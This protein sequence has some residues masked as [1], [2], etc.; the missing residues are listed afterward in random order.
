[1]NV[2]E[3]DIKK[4]ERYKQNRK[5][6]KQLWLELNP[7]ICTLEKK[8]TIRSKLY[9]QEYYKKNKERLAKY[10]KDWK[11][12][13]KD[14]VTITDCIY[15]N[16]HL[17]RYREYNKRY[18]ENN[19]VKI[20]L[21]HSLIRDKS[22]KKY[23]KKQRLNILLYQK[24][25]YQRKKKEIIM[26]QALTYDQLGNYVKNNGSATIYE[27][28]NKFNIS[29]EHILRSFQKVILKFCDGQRFIKSYE[30]N[31]DKTGFKLIVGYYYR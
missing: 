25:Y 24:E 22:D 30:N 10:N 9:Q 31:P 4:R 16:K 14:R 18:R 2:Y 29:R 20:S 1:M 21:R 26:K 3:S 27:L 19:K 13:N 12:K 28:E 11:R 15:R 6:Q 8:R 23:Y 7:T 5:E 17:E